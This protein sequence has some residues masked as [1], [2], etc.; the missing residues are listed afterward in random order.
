MRVRWQREFA[1]AV[2]SGPKTGLI[3]ELGAC[4]T[5]VE[6]VHVWVEWPYVARDWHGDRGRA[7]AWTLRV[8]RPGPGPAG[9]RYA[10]PPAPPRAPWGTACRG[11]RVARAEKRSALPVAVRYRLYR[12][13]V[14]RCTVPCTVQYG[15]TPHDVTAKGKAETMA[16]REIS[17]KL[18]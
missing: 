8:G 18:G 14:S 12:T 9:P 6:T 3:E 10:G 2:P 17:R 4:G 7:C 5:T 15:I 11:R 1:T 13:A 16:E